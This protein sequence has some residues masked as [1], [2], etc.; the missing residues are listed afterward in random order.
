VHY[1]LDEGLDDTLQVCRA[2]LTAE[3][4]TA[5]VKMLQKTRL[6]RGSFFVAPR[7]KQQ[8]DGQTVTRARE[9]VVPFGHHA[10]AKVKWVRYYCVCSMFVYCVE[11]IQYTVATY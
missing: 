1:Q 6:A 3:K 4:E 5:I 7:W 8:V 9:K 11:C 10:M 2:A